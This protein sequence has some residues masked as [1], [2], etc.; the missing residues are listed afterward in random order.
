MPN[1]D[2]A[3]IHLSSDRCRS[4]NWAP[5]SSSFGLLLKARGRE[6]QQAPQHNVLLALAK[7][8]PAACLSTVLR[9]SQQGRRQE[10]RGLF[11]KMW[12][13][14]SH[15]PGLG[16]NWAWLLTSVLSHRIR[17]VAEVKNEGL[18]EEPANVPWQ[19]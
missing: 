15:I 3:A 16:A 12:N 13:Q 18:I 4:M 2:T 6:S 10:E 11:A 17:I 7:G 19:A 14:P 8:S 5:S 9:H 1:G